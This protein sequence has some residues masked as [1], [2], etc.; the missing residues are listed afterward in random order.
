MLGSV[1]RSKSYEQ[2]GLRTIGGVYGIH[3]FHIV[4]AGNLL[5]DWRSHGLL[6]SFLRRHQGS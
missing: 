4:D 5:F 1:L 6:E 3:V 2:R